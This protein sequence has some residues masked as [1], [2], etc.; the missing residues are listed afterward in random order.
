VKI[1]YWG[2]IAV[3]V[4][5]VLMAGLI[6]SLEPATR[7]SLNP[8]TT[9][10]SVP[11]TGVILRVCEPSQGGYA[12]PLVPEQATPISVVPFSNIQPSQ[13]IPSSAWSAR[14]GFSISSSTDPEYW[15]KM[16]GSGWYLDWRTRQDKP[17]EALQHWQMLRL[18]A[19]CISPSPEAIRSTAESLPGQVWIIGNEPDVIWQDN[20]TPTRYAVVYHELYW[21][22][23]SF[24]PSALIAVGGIS[25]ATPLRL[26]YLDQVLLAYQERYHQLLPADWWTVHGY[27]LREQQGSWGVE[28]PPGLD[29]TQ[30]ELYEVSDHS[31]LDL[32]EAQLI[33]FRQWMK[34]NG[35]QDTPLALTE[36]G[37]LMPTSYGFP[38]ETVADY[39]EQ[40]FTWLYQAQ[41]ESIGYPADA[42]HLVQKWAWFSVSDSTYPSSDLGEIASGK[43]TLVGE[44]FRAMVAMSGD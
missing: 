42:Y 32:F 25:Q 11:T 3:V 31:R 23:K 33:S 27:V 22:I 39:L 15:A 43:L 4:V 35:Y 44:R 14:A 36:F 12:G 2:V 1:R 29:A 5:L 24:D 37:I 13:A 41:D 7:L 20:V 18:R 16:L 10:I 26:Q 38:P 9:S 30:G 34:A 6:D 21:L 40:T 28:I 19:D 8:A 17:A